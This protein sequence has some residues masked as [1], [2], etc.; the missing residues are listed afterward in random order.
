MN[1]A[2][3]KNLILKKFSEFVKCLNCCELEKMIIGN[4]SIFYDHNRNIFFLFPSMENPY[5][6]G[7]SATVV[8]DFAGGAVDQYQCDEEGWPILSNED[9]DDL[10][11]MMLMDGFCDLDCLI[12]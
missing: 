4:K 6:Y 3:R 9:C 12:E 1:Y 5:R 11:E 8:A 2:K 10:R 7:I